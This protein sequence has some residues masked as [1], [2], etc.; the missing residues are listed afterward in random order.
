MNASELDKIVRPLSKPVYECDSQ[1]SYIATRLA[2]Y[3]KGYGSVDLNPDYQRG[4]VWTKAQQSAFIEAAFRGVLPSSAFL[5]QL[6]CP[7]WNNYDKYNGDLP[8]GFQC[9]DGLQ[10][11]TAIQS[12]LDGDVEVF[13]MT[14]RDFDGS[15]YGAKDIRYRI[16][17]SV[18]DFETKREV[19]E[20]Y[21]A[22]NSGGTPHSVDELD[23]VRGM[24]NE[25]R[26]AA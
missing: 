14:V 22:H 2:S 15:R 16:R 3:A 10:R 12:Y 19:L 11:L 23:R 5:V 4:H 25:S 13:G 9:I 7:N 8:R 6:N 24:L 20:H 1:W 26:S 17:I 21:L 18:F